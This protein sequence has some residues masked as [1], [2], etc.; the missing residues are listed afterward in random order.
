MSL[1]AI[2]CLLASLS[3]AAS[4]QQKAKIDEAAPNFTL[5]DTEGKEHSLKNYK[6]KVV[7]LE[8]NNM[9]CPFVKKHYDS[10]NMQSLQKTYTEKGIVWLTICSS[11][12]GKQGYYSAAD[13]QKKI[14]GK[15]VLSTAY[16]LDSD[17][18]VG[19]TYG[20]KTTPHM[21]VIDEKGVL[22]YA[23]AIDDK[24]STKQA[25]VKGANNYVSDCLNACLDG[26]DV[27]VKTST[28]YGCSVKYAQ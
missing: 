11:G 9:D 24:P 5:V 23:G 4:D 1:A 6:G 22:V 17:G 18:S 16:L 13:M 20:A 8:W 19:K 2:V 21:F 10:E 3:F 25:D 15:K 26:G 12:P 27:A 7:V 28:P 14:D